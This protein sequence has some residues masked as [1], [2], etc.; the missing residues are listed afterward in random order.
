MFE[1]S[2]ATHRPITPNDPAC[3]SA[4]TSQR[5]PVGGGESSWSSRISTDV[6]ARIS[7]MVIPTSRIAVPSRTASEARRRVVPPPGGPSTSERSRWAAR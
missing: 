7:G 1:V 3:Q 2:R 4:A 6:L 5:I